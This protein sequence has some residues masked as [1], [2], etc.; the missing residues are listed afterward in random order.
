MGDLRTEEV[1][2]SVHD[3][4][5]EARRSASPTRR[6]NR[7]R[8]ESGSGHFSSD[9]TPR[10][11]PEDGMLYQPPD[12]L[13]LA[14]PKGDESQEEFDQ[15][16]RHALQAGAGRR[17]RVRRDSRALGVS[18][19]SASSLGQLPV[20]EQSPQQGPDFKRGSPQAGSRRRKTVGDTDYSQKRQQGAALPTPEPAAAAIEQDAFGDVGMHRRRRQRASLH[21]IALSQ[22]TA[23]SPTAAGGSGARSGV[24]NQRGGALSA[25]MRSRRELMMADDSDEGSDTLSPR[26]RRRHGPMMLEDPENANGN[27]SRGRSRRRPSHNEPVSPSA[28]S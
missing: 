25:Q 2:L 24:V 7:G 19:V 6:R 11:E 20:T 4:G 22:Q 15:G 3:D 23:S 14:S 13:R 10:L 8:S 28:W 1:D 9:R 27:L 18:L 5:P 12:L 21:K 26:N 16:D 17:R